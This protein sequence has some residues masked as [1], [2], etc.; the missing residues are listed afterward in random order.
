MAVPLCGGQPLPVTLVAFV[1]LSRRDREVYVGVACEC[2][3]EEEHGPQRVSRRGERLF[4]P[5]RVPQRSLQAGRMC[6]PSPDA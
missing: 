5:A 1:P 2:A 3:W 4:F 6:L